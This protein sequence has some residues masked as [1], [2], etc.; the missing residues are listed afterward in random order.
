MISK[1]NFEQINYHNQEDWKKVLWFTEDIFKNHGHRLKKLKILAFEVSELIERVS[2][3]IHQNT[4]AVCPYCQNVCCINRHS[5]YEH[6]DIVYILAIGEKVPSYRKGIDDKAPCQFLGLNGCTIRRSVRPYRCT[7]YFCDPLL[8]H[9]NN[10]PSV[11]YRRFISNLEQIT[12]KR[13]EMLNTF[14]E[15][16]HKIN[17]E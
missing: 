9:I 17:T 4:E 11:E 5:Y 10:S 6:H 2:P 3:F 12:R 8:E 16:M 13:D 1:Y 15:I 14:I 7:W